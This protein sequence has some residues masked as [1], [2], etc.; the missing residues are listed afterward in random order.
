MSAIAVRHEAAAEPRPSQVI[1]TTCSMITCRNGS[2]P[3]LL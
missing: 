3:W 1:I 2:T